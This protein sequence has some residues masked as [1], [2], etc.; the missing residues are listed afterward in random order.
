MCESRRLQRLARH[1]EVRRAQAE[2][3]ILSPAQRPLARALRHQPHTHSDPRLYAHFAGDGEDLGEFLQLLHDEDHALAEPRAEQR[4]LDELAVFISVANDERFR[5]PMN[6]H[7]GKKLRLAARLDAK[8]ERLT[9]QHDLLHHF[10]ELV[11]F[12]RENPAIHIVVFELLD[13][14][15]KRLIDRLHAMLEQ[16]LKPQHHREAKPLRL[17]LRDEVHDVDRRRSIQRR[18]DLHVARFVDAEVPG[19]PTVDVIK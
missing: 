3:R 4:I 14:R 8:M 2:L 9:R 7:R 16:V 13:R 18:K 10:L 12:D 19:S 1:D 11:H 15:A 17:R 5:V 6:R